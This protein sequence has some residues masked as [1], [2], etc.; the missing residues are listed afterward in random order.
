[1]FR[2]TNVTEREYKDENGESVF[3]KVTTYEDRPIFGFGKKNSEESDGEQKP[4]KSLLK[5][6]A[7]GAGIGAGILGGVC[8]V[9]KMTKK[10]DSESEEYL[11]SEASDPEETEEPVESDDSSE[12]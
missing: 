12:G 9:G 1:M 4:K 6:L 11:P 5:K 2:K 10:S 8:L 3:E 7:I